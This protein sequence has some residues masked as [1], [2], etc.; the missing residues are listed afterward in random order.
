MLKSTLIVLF[1]D[2]LLLASSAASFDLEM[3]MNAQ[4]PI[5]RTPFITCV[6]NFCIEMLQA[7]V[8]YGC[9]GDLCIDIINKLSKSCKI[10]AIEISKGLHYS[11]VDFINNSNNVKL[12]RILCDEDDSPGEANLL[13]A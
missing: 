2:L 8:N 3:S 10:C 12:Q 9:M 13:R 7:A 5:S 4:M 11:M 6:N 1:G